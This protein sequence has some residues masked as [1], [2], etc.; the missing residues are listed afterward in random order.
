MAETFSQ[1]L[2]E[3]VLTTLDELKAHEVRV[4]DVR[5][6]TSITDA[7]II[8]SGTSDR[9]VKTLAEGV[10]RNAKQAG[11][12]VAGMEGERDAEWILLDLVD[13]L[14]HVMLPRT[15]HFYNL[16]KLWSV[17]GEV[18]ETETG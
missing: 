13:V 2:Q 15:R 5:G 7:M 12:A 1:P 10:G 14:V 9:H 16:E 4:L 3:V 18:L 6:K 8:A 11:Y 17:E